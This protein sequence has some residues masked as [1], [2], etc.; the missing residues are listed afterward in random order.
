M[1]HHLLTN[2]YNFFLLKLLLLILTVRSE[3][4]SVQP[5]GITMSGTISPQ[6]GTYKFPGGITLEVPAGA[7]DQDTEIT[8]QPVDKTEL[9]SIFDQRG[10]SNEK[11]YSYQA[12]YLCNPDVPS[13][14]YPPTGLAHIEIS[15]DTEPMISLEKGEVT[16]TYT[17]GDLTVTYTLTLQRDQ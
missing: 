9:M 4:S 3:K 2:R 15:E 12:C 17:F 16:R 11:F 14:C 1:R 7:V 13:E 6:G 5:E 10:V 8:L